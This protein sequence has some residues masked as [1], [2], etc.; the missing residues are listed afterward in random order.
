M[1]RSHTFGTIFSLVSFFCAGLLLSACG[2]KST[3]SPQDQISSSL[4]IGLSSSSHPSLSSP[5][6]TGDSVGFMRFTLNNNPMAAFRINASLASYAGPGDDYFSNTLFFQGE[7][8]VNVVDSI[9]TQIVAVFVRNPVTGPNQDL[10]LTTMK[11]WNTQNRVAEEFFAIPDS[12]FVNLDRFAGG[13]VRGTFD[14]KMR[15]FGCSAPC[16]EEDESRIVGSF[17]TPYLNR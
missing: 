13:F 14:I 17:D 11:L 16:A 6:L 7:R 15:R 3:A 8:D 5:G 12:G 1:F 4:G 2:E 9:V 10:Q